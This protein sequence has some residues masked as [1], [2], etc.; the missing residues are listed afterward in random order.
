MNEAV[1]LDRVE[2]QAIDPDIEKAVHEAQRPWI[3]TRY[4]AHQREIGCGA[5][6]YGLMAAILDNLYGHLAPH[7]RGPAK[8]PVMSPSVGSCSDGGGAMVL[9]FRRAFPLE[10]VEMSVEP[11]DLIVTRSFGGGQGPDWP[12]HVMMAGKSMGQVIH[13]MPGTGCVWSSLASSIGRVVKIYRPRGK[14]AWP[15]CGGFS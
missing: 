12:G 10:E 11:G 6:C 13:T 15:C 9:A 2:W 7:G 3:G 14:D 4:S 8:L 1:P 5:S